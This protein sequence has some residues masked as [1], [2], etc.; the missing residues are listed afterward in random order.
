MVMASSAPPMA[1]EDVPATAPPGSLEVIGLTARFRGATHSV[2]AVDDLSFRV[3]PGETL[4]IVGESGSG[5]SV[6][7]L[8]VMRL[9]NGRNV[10]M[11]GSVSFFDRTGTSWNLMTADER[12][13]NR[14]RGGDLAMIFQDASA[15]L[16]PLFSVGDQIAETVQLHRGCARKAAWAEAVELLRQVGIAAPEHRA[17]DYPH[18]LSGGMRQ[19]AMIAIALAGEPL[20]LIADEPTT[21]L[22][23]T[24]QAQIL[25]LLKELQRERGLAIILVT[26]DLGVVADFADRLL[27]MYAGQ[28]VEQGDANAVLSAPRHPY[29]ASLLACLPD[30]TG[31]APVA[32]RRA[33]PGIVPAIHDAFEGCRFRARC[34]LAEPRCESHV[35]LAE[36]APNWQSRCWL[37]PEASP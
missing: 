26:H 14:I 21:A 3:A 20:L 31:E 5:K 29:T 25:D 2:H 32:H 35:P 8:S 10:E 19:R 9:L 7:M 24:I 17:Y 12:T 11:S 1:R 13:L 23:V 6:S 36:T 16:N 4:A 27:V 15:S 30:P 37:W 34:P 18:Q 22:D 33:R 28:L